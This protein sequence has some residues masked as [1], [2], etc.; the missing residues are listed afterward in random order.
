[1]TAR[2]ITFIEWLKAVLAV[3]LIG[4]GVITVISSL[5]FLEAA[6][7]AFFI[8]LIGLMMVSGGAVLAGA[9]GE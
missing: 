1:M 5:F 4:A 7:I 2:I 8:C 9:D 6:F 3:V